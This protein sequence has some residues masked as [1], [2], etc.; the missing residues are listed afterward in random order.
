MTVNGEVISIS[1]DLQKI[2]VVI[3]LN[4]SGRIE[5]RLTPNEAKPYRLGRYVDVNISPHV[6]HG[7]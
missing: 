1:K 2:L 3:K 6:T 7:S 4:Y 5:L